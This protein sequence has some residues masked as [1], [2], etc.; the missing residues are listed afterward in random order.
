MPRYGIFGRATPRH[1]YRLVVVLLDKDTA[2]RQ[3]EL[4]KLHMQIEG[5]APCDYYSKEISDE[6]IK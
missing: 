6:D 1:K 3:A 4:L 5:A 2:K